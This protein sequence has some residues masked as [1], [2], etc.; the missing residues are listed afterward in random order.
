M[1]EKVLFLAVLLASQLSFAQDKAT[2]A[3]TL[4]QSRR[5]YPGGRDDSDLTVQKMKVKPGKQDLESTQAHGP[6]DEEVTEG[7]E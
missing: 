5:M 3:Q 2:N 4:T 6:A 7:G 1:I